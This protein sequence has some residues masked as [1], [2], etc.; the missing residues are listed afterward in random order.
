M[1]RL[2]KM[3]LLAAFG[4]TIGAQRHSVAAP[5]C[6]VPATIEQPQVE[7][8][9]AR[10]VN[11]APVT[12]YLLALSWSP[13]FCR[14][15]QG[16]PRHESQCNGSAPFG[17]ILHGLWPEGDGHDDPAWCAPTNALPLVQI[18]ANFCMMPSAKLQ[19]HEWAK[20]GTC[21]TR[22]PARYFK[23][24]GILFNA[25]RVPDMDAVSRQ[26]TTVATFV[27]TLSVINTGL[28]AT[29]I[30]I[31]NGRGDWLKG[32]N[33]CLGKD[34]RPRACPAQ[35][36]RSNASRPLKIWRAVK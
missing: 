9:N 36:G 23:A 7:H 14:E 30:Q 15:H 32:V 18:R 2:L 26:G 16:D 8:P 4:L 5:H 17:F 22:E 13:Q 21:M 35:N 25:L 20:H 6:A 12:G 34:F 1:I 19:Q 27:K 3:S 33:I 31:D 10:E 28:P 29:A 11:I 24:A